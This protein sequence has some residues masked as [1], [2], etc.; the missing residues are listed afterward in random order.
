M[1][2]VTLRLIQ[3]RSRRLEQLLFLEGEQ[4]PAS[5]KAASLEEAL[6]QIDESFSEMLLRKIDEKGMKDPEC[7]KKANIDR[8][9]FSRSGET[10]CTGPANLRQP[11]LP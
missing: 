5:Y 7:Y 9:L 10:D 8:K 3:D 11:P 6:S 4:L 2:T 1:T